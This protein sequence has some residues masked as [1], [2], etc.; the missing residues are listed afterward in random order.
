MYR[1]QIPQRPSLV[2]TSAGC[3][4]GERR[5]EGAGGAMIKCSDGLTRS[6][7]VTPA[8]LLSSFRPKQFLGN[9]GDRGS[10]LPRENLARM[11]RV[12][13]R[14]IPQTQACGVRESWMEGEGESHPHLKLHDVRLCPCLSQTGTKAH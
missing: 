6:C 10:F 5:V 14:E 13:G 4:Y 7:P 12:R 2:V 1:F 11:G 3:L 8:H 9:E